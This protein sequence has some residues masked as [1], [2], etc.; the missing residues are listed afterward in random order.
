MKA[1]KHYDMKKAYSF[2]IYAHQTHLIIGGNGSGKTTLLHMMAG[3]VTPK[4]GKI[5]MK[6]MKV[7][8]LKSLKYIPTHLTV[9]AYFDL[10][11]QYYNWQY[12]PLL[13]HVFKL[14]LHKTIQTL[15]FGQKQKL[16]IIQ[17]FMGNPDMILL[18]EPLIGLDAESIKHFE[19]Y[20]K[21]HTSTI[22]MTTHIPIAIDTVN[23]QL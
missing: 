13:L 21:H 23:I 14:P 5:L 11:Y 8:Y 18:D 1:V 22:I 7:S 10:L 15:S 3:Y 2:N 16:V 19:T 4:F 9:K 20:L 17:S 6:H 12:D